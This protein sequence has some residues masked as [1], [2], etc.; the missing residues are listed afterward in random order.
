MSQLDVDVL[1]LHLSERI[2][3]ENN[4]LPQAKTKGKRQKERE[5]DREK[6][7]LTRS[8]PCLTVNRNLNIA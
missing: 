4:S 5:R 8:L 1:F 2:H 7:K 3:I 6:G